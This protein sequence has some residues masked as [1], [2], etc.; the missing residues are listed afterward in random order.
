M[1][2]DPDPPGDSTGDAS[3]PLDSTFYLIERVR[4]G[5]REALDRLLA[6]HAGPLRRWISGRLP[7][8]ARDL[9]DTDDLV[10]DTLLRTFRKMEDFEPRHVGALQAYLRQAVLNRLRDELRRKGRA[11]SM[12]DLEDVQLEAAGSPLEEAIGREA[13]DRYEAALARLKPEEREAIIAHVEMDYTY[14]EL[15]E[16][17]GKP[18]AEAARKAA[19]RALVRLAEEMKRGGT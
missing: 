1:A 6:R 9:A 2:K 11:P 17:L 16:A 14:E 4:Q 3:L 12:V 8:W 13:V 18:S 19:Q 15:A 10:Q 5:D 7:R